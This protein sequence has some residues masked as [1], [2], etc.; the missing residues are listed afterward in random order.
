MS[1]NGIAGFDDA[2]DAALEEL[3][4]IAAGVLEQKPERGGGVSSRRHDSIAIVGPQSGGDAEGF[5]GEA[6]ASLSA[7]SPAPGLPRPRMRGLEA[8]G[9]RVSVFGIT[10]EQVCSG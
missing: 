5:V 6:P 9:E 10:R 1:A 7:R 4:L 3:D 2:A 8:E